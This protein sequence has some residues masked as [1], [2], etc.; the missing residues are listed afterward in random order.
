MA[1]ERLL[2]P[3]ERVK[4]LYEY[5]AESGEFRDALIKAQDAKTTAALIEQIEDVLDLC[6]MPNNCSGCTLEYIQCPDRRHYDQWQSLKQSLKHTGD[7]WCDPTCELYDG[8]IC[9]AVEHCHRRQVWKQS[10][11]VKE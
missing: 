2:T 4:L 11:E 8:R 6:H 9:D 1:N 5:V 7:V 3:E 10:L